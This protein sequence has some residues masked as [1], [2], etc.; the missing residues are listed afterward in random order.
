MAPLESQSTLGSW[1]SFDAAEQAEEE[2]YNEELDNLAVAYGPPRQPSLLDPSQDEDAATHDYGYESYM[3]RQPSQLQYA[4]SSTS[5]TSDATA[6]SIA[7]CGSSTSIGSATS[8]HSDRTVATQTSGTLTTEG[9]FYTARE[10][11]SDAPSD[12]SSTV[13][14]TSYDATDSMILE[15]EDRYRHIWESSDEST[16]V[17][18][19][20]TLSRNASRSSLASDSSFTSQATSIASDDNPSPPRPLS[21]PSP[22]TRT[23]SVNTSLVPSRLECTPKVSSRLPYSIGGLAQP[24]STSPFQKRPIR[25]VDSDMEPSSWTAIGPPVGWVEGQRAY[26][27]EVAAEQKRVAAQRAADAAAW[28]EEFPSTPSSGL[29][30]MR[31]LSQR[32]TRSNK[33]YNSINRK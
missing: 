30:P 9:S 1:Q 8:A 19:G 4:D 20:R 26:K 15:M 5:I 7:S 2:D 22:F 16:T 3:G 6:R 31:T 21:R 23:P 18:S 27:A 32:T 17:Y 25:R 24:P 11:L 28:E 12:A 14:S 33:P 13:Y 10:Y 29:A